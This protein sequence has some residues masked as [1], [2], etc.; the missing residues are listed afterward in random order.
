MA[1]YN[2]ITEHIKSTRWSKGQSG[3]PKGRPKGSKNIPTIVNEVLY[4][5]SFHLTLKDGSIVKGKPIEAI[6]KALTIK[7]VMGDLKAV[8]LVFEY[9]QSNTTYNV[10]EIFDP[11]D[12][13]KEFIKEV[14]TVEKVA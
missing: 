9:I 4:D 2:P 8:K 14:E 5:E 13:L 6:V 12:D 7:A 1:N 11:N 3:N 10:G